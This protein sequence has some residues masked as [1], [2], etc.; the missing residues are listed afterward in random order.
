MFSLAQ[1]YNHSYGCSTW[2]HS[3]ISHL[4]CSVV[5]FD[6]SQLRIIF[7]WN[8][9]TTQ[10]KCYIKSYTHTQTHNVDQFGPE[11][12]LDLLST[13]PHYFHRIN[14]LNRETICSQFICVSSLDFCPLSPR[15]S[16]AF[17]VDTFLSCLQL[18]CCCCCWSI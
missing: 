7:A 16:K 11:L 14:E 15:A 4:L 12:G 18:F 13:H 6:Y 17:I 3:S 8:A 10:N 9:N 2:I 1:S 5:R